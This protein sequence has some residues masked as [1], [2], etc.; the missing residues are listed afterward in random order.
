MADQLE[1]LGQWINT[2]IDKNET[3]HNHKETM[4]WTAT[5]VWL[6]ASGYLYV[7][8]PT[9]LWGERVLFSLV[10]T[11]MAGLTIW[12]AST[13]FDWRWKAADRTTALREALREVCVRIDV[14]GRI[15]TLPPHRLRM[16]DE[17]GFPVFVGEHLAPGHTIPRRRRSITVLMPWSGEDYDP[18]WNT[19]LP[20]Y[21]AIVVA[22]LGVMCRVW[23]SGGH[24]CV[25]RYLM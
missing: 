3:Y 14:Y 9:W 1:I 5:A 15:A 24:E 23:I 25:K 19:E 7:N 17:C 20:S 8:I 11:I 10:Y 18:R 6:T 12:F 16:M 2:E 22:W 13:Q 4:A 21:A